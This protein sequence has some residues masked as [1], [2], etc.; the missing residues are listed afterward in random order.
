MNYPKLKLF[1]IVRTRDNRIGIVLGNPV[2]LCV[3]VLG[4]GC[5]WFIPGEGCSDTRSDEY[6]E[7]LTIGSRWV[8]NEDPRDYDIMEVWG[9]YNP[10]S[11]ISAIE[12]NC[13]VDY[14][15]FMKPTWIRENNEVADN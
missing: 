4:H 5:T 6:L 1:D 13:V 9:G 11:I 7:D 8:Y 12:R 2:K 14:I 10:L 3:Y 15:K